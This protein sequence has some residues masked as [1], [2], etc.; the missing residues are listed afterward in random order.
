[1]P[2]GFFLTFPS[3]SLHSL[4]SHSPTLLP[5]AI[6]PLRPKIL[7]IIYSILAKILAILAKIS[8]GSDFVLPRVY[9]PAFAERVHGDNPHGS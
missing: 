1:M 4:S 9:A 8:M 5:I 7:A 3:S 2:F 6:S